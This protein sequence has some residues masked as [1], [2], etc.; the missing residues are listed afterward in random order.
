MSISFFS[1]NYKKNEKIKY[2]TKKLNK[3]AIEILLNIEIY[4]F[5]KKEKKKE[6][7]EILKKHISNDEN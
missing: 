5:I 3:R 4:C 6:F 1:S 2:L 7:L